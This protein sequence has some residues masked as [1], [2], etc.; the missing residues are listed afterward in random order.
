MPFVYRLHHQLALG[1]T[2]AWIL[3]V[4]ALVWTLDCLAGAWLTLPVFGR[5]RRTGWWSSWWRAWQIRSG[6]SRYQTQFDLHRAAGLWLW[7]MLFVLAWSSVG[8]NLDSV[9]RPVMETAFEHQAPVA[10]RS[11]PPSTSQT[12]TWDEALHQGERL[13]AELAQREGFSIEQA[14]RLMYDP[15]RQ[16]FR[17]VAQTDRDRA[18]RWGSTSVYFDAGDGSLLGSFVPTGKAAGDTVTHWLTVLHMAALG[19][20]PYQAFVTVTGLA[21]ALLSATGLYLWWRKRAARRLLQRF[22]QVDAGGR[23]TAS[24]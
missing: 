10:L 16:R 23:S 7:A 14:D 2:G 4:V 12:M 17:Y 18:E 22:E 20:A 19:G 8:L 21:V 13:M 11:G 6:R 3:G 24:S 1:S 5:G 9:Y 15:E